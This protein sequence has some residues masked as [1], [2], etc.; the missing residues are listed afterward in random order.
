M[1]TSGPS[2]LH[3]TDLQLDA[4]VLE[5]HLKEFI[6]RAEAN[7]IN[8]HFP[9][10]FEPSEVVIVF[11]MSLP[12]GEEN[13]TVKIVLIP[14]TVLVS[15]YTSG[16]KNMCSFH[17][18]VPRLR[19]YKREHASKNLQSFVFSSMIDYICSERDNVDLLSLISSYAPA[20]TPLSDPDAIAM[21]VA[22]TE[23]TADVEREFLAATLVAGDSQ[24]N[25]VIYSENY[26]QPQLY[27][28]AFKETWPSFYRSGHYEKLLSL[29]P[30]DQEALLQLSP[31]LKHEMESI[32]NAYHKRMQ[33]TPVPSLLPQ[34]DLSAPTPPQ[35]SASTAPSP[36]ADANVVQSTMVQALAEQIAP[37]CL[38][39][40]ELF[41]DLRARDTTTTAMIEATKREA[42]MIEATKREA[43]EIKVAMIEAAKRETE[44]R[45]RQSETYFLLGRT[46]IMCGDLLHQFR[47]S[48]V[49]LDDLL[50]VAVQ[51]LEAEHVALIDILEKQIHLARESA[52]HHPFDTLYVDLGRMTEVVTEAMRP[53]LQPQCLLSSRGAT[54]STPSNAAVRGTVDAASRAFP[55]PSTPG[56][57]EFYQICYRVLCRHT[58]TLTVR[59]CFERQR[60]GRSK[61]FDSFPV[62]LSAPPRFD[63]TTD[64]LRRANGVA[65]SSGSA[66]LSIDLVAPLVTIALGL[67]YGQLA[68]HPGLLTGSFMTSNVTAAAAEG[69]RDALASLVTIASLLESTLE[70]AFRAPSTSTQPLASA[71]SSASTRSSAAQPPNNPTTALAHWVPLGLAQ[72]VLLTAFMRAAVPSHASN[73]DAPTSQLPPLFLRALSSLVLPRPDCGAEELARLMESEAPPLAPPHMAYLM[74]AQMHTGFNQFLSSQAFACLRLVQLHRSPLMHAEGSSQV[75][76]VPQNG[77]LPSSRTESGASKPVLIDTLIPVLENIGISFTILFAFLVSTTSTQPVPHAPQLPPA[78]QVVSLDTPASSPPAS[79]PPAPAPA[80]RADESSLDESSRANSNRILEIARSSALGIMI[81]KSTNISSVSPSNTGLLLIAWDRVLKRGVLLR[82][83]IENVSSIG[84]R[85]VEESRS[86]A[87]NADTPFTLPLPD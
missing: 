22:F 36:A 26:T 69:M 57:S 62:L 76:A 51:R 83:F 82:D 1:S 80:A 77:E 5:T 46:E 43:A 37:R 71:H 50:S 23:A 49:P 56:L 21:N 39:V 32:T 4:E 47:A 31:I 14:E 74:D 72:L 10:F 54:A 3:L 28:P 59:E 84:R 11:L 6:S 29:I 38:E 18:L 55:T 58:H 27:N 81:L 2:V 86:L 65:F 35:S 41:Q 48:T 44:T 20:G 60:L 63:D 87:S 12:S 24:A 40:F 52:C 67:A 34:T 66:H 45:M 42:A 78:P 70:S 15:V 61:T 9:T 85:V 68:S 7:N 16:E 75:N 33:N 73:P 8:R 17:S 64:L 13:F 53:Q 79:S 30:A 19:G 25:F